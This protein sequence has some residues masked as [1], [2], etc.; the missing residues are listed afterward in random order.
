MSQGCK[1]ITGVTLILKQDN[2]ILLFKRNIPGKIAY[3]LFA[4]PGGTVEANESVIHTACR[5]AEEEMGITIDPQDVEIVHLIRLR[6]KYDPVSQE[7]QQ[8][9]MLYFAQVNKWQGQ[10][11]NL[12]PHKHSD[13]AWFDLNALPSNIFDLNLRALEDIKRGK[14]IGEQ[15]WEQ[16]NLQDLTGQ[17]EI[18]KQPTTS[19]I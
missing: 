5:E 12:E 11:Q 1:V 14:F 8:I 3:G 19:Q 2:K 17:Q 4:L 15:G 7:T 13:L 10:P 6:E 18:L 16:G 9:L